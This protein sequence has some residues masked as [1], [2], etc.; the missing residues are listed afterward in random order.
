MSTVID[1]D[2]HLFEYRGLWEE[3]IDPAL[4]DEAIRFVDDEVGNV[5]VKWRGVELV[6][7]D[8]QLPGETDAIGER[9]RR[10][11]AGEA[12]EHRYDDALPRDYWDPSARAGR[13]ASL[14]LDE[15]VL[16]PNY[17]LAWERTLNRHLPA[18][19]GNMAAWNR[20]CA[21]VVADGRGQLHPVAHLS[22]RDLDWLDDQLRALERAGVHLAMI[23]PALVDGRPLSH[24]DLDRAWSAFVEHGV[25]PVFH[26]ADQPRPFDDA[27]YTDG[28]ERGVPVLESVFLYMAAALSCTDLIVNGVL[29]RHPDLH[30]GIVELSAVWVP[31]YLMMLDGGTRFVE[32]LNGRSVAQL[33]LPP[34]EYFRRQVR[35]SSFAYELPTNIGRQIGGDDILMCCSDYPHSEGTADPIADYAG[36]GRFAT[37][38]EDAPAFFGDNVA[39]LL[40]R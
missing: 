27:W 35:V 36:I 11:R 7:A 32:R 14:G 29:A 28:E 15:A 24:P 13:L 3:H 30:I 12:P 6:T 40:G 17:G 16:F 9:R 4:R 25:T 33:D 23:A 31:M 18:L 10:E 21:T 26:V 39:L 34:S 37:R 1:S 5:A 38:P 19:L 22:L 20:W 2:Q 8:V